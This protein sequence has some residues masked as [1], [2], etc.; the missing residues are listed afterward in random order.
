M[1]DEQTDAIMKAKKDENV[2]TFEALGVEKLKDRQ[3]LAAAV[4]K[5]KRAQEEAAT[6]AAAGANK[7]V[8]F[9][10][11]CEL[12]HLVDTLKDVPNEKFEW[13]VGLAK[14]QTNSNLQTFVAFL[15]KE[16]FGMK[17]LHMMQVI[18]QMNARA[19]QP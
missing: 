12:F 8:A 15:G 19:P 6:L 13:L 5:A 14:S 11:K 4:L 16:P 9:L 1:S 7:M 3:A 18:T 17:S 10:V 2:K